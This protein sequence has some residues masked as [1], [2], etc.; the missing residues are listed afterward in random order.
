VK[1][2]SLTSTNAER[3][4]RLGLGQVL[5]Y[6]FSL[7]TRAGMRVEAALVV[8]VEPPDASWC[9]LCHSLKMILTWAPAFPDLLL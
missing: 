2:K 7:S 4:L 6:R 9:D 5:R 3:Q 8:E 1:V